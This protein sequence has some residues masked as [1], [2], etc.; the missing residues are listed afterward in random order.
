MQPPLI[1][2]YVR[3]VCIITDSEED[4]LC[5]LRT[6]RDHRCSGEGTNGSD[7]SSVF[8]RHEGC[9]DALTNLTPGWCC[10]FF[11]RWTKRQIYLLQQINGGDKRLL[12]TRDQ[13]HILS[14]FRGLNLVKERG[15]SAPEEPAAWVRNF[16]SWS[17]MHIYIIESCEKQKSVCLCWSEE[18]TCF[19][20]HHI[21]Q[22][23]SYL[24]LY[25]CC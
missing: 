25:Y 23:F 11:W 15:S 14:L 16:L 21:N 2:V 10:S 19:K 5:L 1:Y 17:K 13:V 12:G 22:T 24:S 3:S 4:V 6:L 8:Q 20:R 9:N 18:T 7:S